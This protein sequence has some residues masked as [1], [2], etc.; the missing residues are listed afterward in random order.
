MAEFIQQRKTVVE[1]IYFHNFDYA[2]DTGSGYSFEVT[3]SGELAEPN[4]AAIEN[5]AKCLSGQDERG[6]II[7]KGIHKH[8]RQYR[9]P[10]VLLCNCGQHVELWSSWA[11]GCEKCGQEYNGSGQELASRSQWGYETGETQADFINM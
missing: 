11:N 5:L 1:T 6:Q 8:E 10:A 3:E 9:E 7:D 4:D 2:G